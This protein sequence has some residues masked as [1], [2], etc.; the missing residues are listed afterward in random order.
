MNAYAYARAT[1]SRN[2]NESVFFSLE[3]QHYYNYV[4]FLSTSVRGNYDYITWKEVQNDPRLKCY[5][6]NCFQ[7]HCALCMSRNL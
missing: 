7:I 4:S 2:L 5:Q 6:K 3:L 1:V